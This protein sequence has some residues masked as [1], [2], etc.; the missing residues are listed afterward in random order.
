INA[1]LRKADL[2]LGLGD[3]ATAADRLTRID[4]LVADSAE[5]QLHGTLG[6]LMAE[7]RRRQGDLD[8]ARAAVDEALDRIEFCTEDVARLA[9]V[10]ASGV[11]VEADRAQRGRDLGDEAELARALADIDS[12]L[13]RVQA[14]GEE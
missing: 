11:T 10:A 7:L 4:R 12:Y 14:A 5:P 1:G 9:R 8:G 3:H 13:L 2:A 6:A